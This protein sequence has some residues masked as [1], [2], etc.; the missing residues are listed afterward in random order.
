MPHT[1]DEKL[2]AFNALANAA[3]AIEREM[4]AVTKATQ[5]LIAGAARI[6]DVSGAAIKTVREASDEA[7]TYAANKAF[8]QF[9]GA[10]D[11][12][13]KTRKAYEKA[14]SSAYTKFAQWLLTAVIGISGIMVISTNLAMPNLSELKARW[15]EKQRIEKEITN[16]RDQLASLAKQGQSKQ[17]EMNALIAR[18]NRFKSNNPRNSNVIVPCPFIQN[19]EWCILSEALGGSQQSDDGRNYF[20]LRLEP[21]R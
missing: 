20:I 15:D 16:L 5:A 8:S 19:A 9:N 21:G 1:S 18:V 3:R 6:D 11:A 4:Q 14:A 7:V 10:A 2:Q 12:A 17:I 13:E